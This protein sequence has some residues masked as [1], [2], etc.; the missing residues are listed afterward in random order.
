MDPAKIVG[1]AA[2]FAA[3]IDDYA[4]L[5]C[6][7][8]DSGFH[9]AALLRDSDTVRQKSLKLAQAVGARAYEEPINDE[10]FSAPIVGVLRVSRQLSL[11]KSTQANVDPNVFSESLLNTLPIGGW[12]AV[13]MRVARETIPPRE[14]MRNT[15]WQQSRLGSASPTH[16]SLGQ[17]AV[18]IQVTAGGENWASVRGVL[19]QVGSAMPGFDIPTT[20]RRISRARPASVAGLA[21]AATA[22]LGVAVY[23]Y[24]AALDYGWALTFAPALLC[25]LATIGLL[26][27]I[28]N[29]RRTRILSALD[30]GHWPTPPAKRSHVKKPQQR[31]VMEE[32]TV[33][34][35]KQA[36]E[37]PM[38][39]DTFIVGPHVVIGL[40]SP[41]SG[42]LS[43]SATSQEMNVPPKLADA[44]MGPLLGTGRHG[45]RAHL[46]MAS[47]YYGV[48]LVGQPDS[49]KSQLLRSLYGYML[50]ERRNPSGRPGFPGQSNALVVFESKDGE[51]DYLAWGRALGD[52]ATLINPV[53]DDTPTIDIFGVPG[54]LADRAAFGVNAFKYGFE[55]GAIGDR[56][57]TV[58]VNVFTTALYIDDNPAILDRLHE[59]HEEYSD[60]KAKSGPM[61][62]ANILIGNRG[63]ARA[64][65][66]ADATLA[67]VKDQ[68]EAEG[69]LAGDEAAVEDTITQYFLGRTEASRRS[70]FET[71]TNKID[72]LAK[73]GAWWNPHERRSLTWEQILGGYM[74]V[75]ITTGATE[76]R[77]IAE[78]LGDQLSAM[79][80]YTL[81][82]AI[83]RI[84]A[85]WQSMGRSVSI[86][87]D[88]LAVLAGTSPSTITWFR[89]QGRSYGVRPIFATQ[90]P[91]QLHEKVRTTFLNFVT[92]ASFSQSDTATAQAVASSLSGQ[93][94]EIDESAIK[95]LGKYE[96]VVRTSV[97]QARLRAFTITVS[98]FEGDRSQFPD[99][100]GYDLSSADTTRDTAADMSALESETVTDDEP[101]SA[102]AARPNFSAYT[103]MYG[104]D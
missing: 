96:I 22:A 41:Q 91:D 74:N 89:D 93:E 15:T 103:D 24:T 26:T 47:T 102:P 3:S 64:K 86:F 75:V 32:E 79:I 52:E 20:P 29:T 31:T 2:S 14:R 87:S 17:A 63:D 80:L 6:Y 100:Q 99:T 81:Q 60:V 72:Q 76:R 73:L 39:K 18:V 55:D 84:C 27:G 51:E 85:N 54:S 59:S 9:A 36:G 90:R 49:G 101:D 11:T 70:Y 12:V 67:Q 19:N 30:K 50:L 88:E 65:A 35:G 58:L 7:R 77:N 62:Y 40:V 83:K 23:P 42:A 57:Y 98:N 61:V 66:L 10:V 44:V 78:K 33:R 92:L 4:T 53:D 34:R 94:D 8:L 25:L 43:G 37:Y 71:S 5:V 56:N 68:R 95:H 38:H 97:D 13:S 21:T 45:E 69:E 28:L 46:P 1:E 48:A 104:D 16:H 82:S